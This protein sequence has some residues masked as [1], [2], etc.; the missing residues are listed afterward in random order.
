MTHDLHKKR[1]QTGH[2]VR[3][4]DSTWPFGDLFIH[5]FIFM[6]LTL[7]KKWNVMR[8]CLSLHY[9]CDILVDRNQ[10]IGHSCSNRI[11]NMFKQSYFY[12][13]PC[14]INRMYGIY[15]RKESCYPRSQTVSPAHTSLLWRIFSLVLIKSILHFQRYSV[16]LKMIKN[17]ITMITNNN[18]PKKSLRYSFCMMISCIQRI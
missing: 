9:H 3:Q 13:E 10:R 17:M 1:S 14:S 4:S 15:N 8:L 11:S 16:P 18:L 7:K 6:P 5:F 2:P 12:A